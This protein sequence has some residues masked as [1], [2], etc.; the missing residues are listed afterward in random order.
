MQ[1][2]KICVPVSEPS[3]IGCACMICRAGDLVPQRLQCVGVIGCMAERLKE[4]LF[5]SKNVDIIAGPDALRSIPSLI[6][7]FTEVTHPHILLFFGIS[8]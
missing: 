3:L 8:N 4:R 7:V 2:E 5:E 1:M 6:D